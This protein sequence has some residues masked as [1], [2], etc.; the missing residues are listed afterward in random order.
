MRLVS[1]LFAISAVVGL[2]APTA[3]HALV[4]KYTVSLSGTNESPANASP[5]AGIGMV[6]FD[7]GPSTMRVEVSFSGLTGNTTA[8]HIHCCSAV[9]NA[10]TAGVAT[11]T[12]SFT[13]FQLG[14]KSSIYD[15]TFVMTAPS[16]SWN[17]A[18]VTAN[19]GTPAT[20]FI[21][22]MNGAAAGK[23]YLNIHTTTFGG[24]EIRGFLAPVPEPTTY[25]LMLGGLGL[26]G[27]AAKRRQQA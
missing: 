26:I 25:A 18:F 9:A 23:A 16:G 19:G 24:G 21:A 5:G 7:T 14:V 27:W 11:V 22:L 10:G 8:S 17:N 1:T 15:H 13:G 3:S 2:S 6:T 20:A 12:P 4:V